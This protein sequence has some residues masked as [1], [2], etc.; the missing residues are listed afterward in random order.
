MGA[1]ILTC[2]SKS[3]NNIYKTAL[4]VTVLSSLERFLGF[5]YR[6]IL[7]RTIGSEGMG[8]YQIALSLFAVFVTAVSSGIPITVSRLITKHKAGGD[9]R[10]ERSAVSAGILLSLM[11]S[12]PVFLAVTLG[13]GLVSLLFADE[14]CLSIFLILS[15][16]LIFTSVYAVLRGALWGNRQFFTFSVIEL[17]EELVM[18]TLGTLLV[19]SAVSAADGA[20]R[21]AVAVT[22]SYVTSF[23]IAVIYFICKGGRLSSPKRQLKP[24]ILSSAPITAMRTSSS[25]INSLIAIILPARLMAAGMTSAEALSEFGMTSGMAVPVLFIPSTVIG[26]IAL[27]LVPELAE[28]FY[29]GRHGALK[30]DIENALKIS[31]AIACALIP[32]LFV[33]GE[34]VGVLLYS[35][36][37]SGKIISVF[38]PIL[39]PLSLNMI[40]TSM[41]NSMNLERKT[42]LYYLIS[43]AAMLAV[44]FIAPQ[45]IGA[46]ALP[47]GM[48]L[49]F[50]I[51]SALN[52]R[53]THK[54]CAQK[55]KYLSYMIKSCLC[56]I[57]AAAA[58]KAVY[59]LF[60][61]LVSALPA[62]IFTA[63]A[64]LGVISALF[65]ALGLISFK[66]VKKLLNKKTQQPLT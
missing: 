38:C 58:G 57:P 42:L 26:S 12:I 36:A 29:K 52:L 33:L 62:M 27:V 41:L 8:L 9:K 61:K 7:S 63:V 51:S 28:N 49:S 40:S 48:F 60:N 1:N 16:G 43:S 22:V 45:F 34:D 46:M 50:I 35:N 23:A 13:R 21:A 55:P 30:R 56:V 25:L 3:E 10:G 39:L 6:I 19:L 66:P 64:I 5:L 54:T 59:S 24:L 31:S 20:R 15:P 32:L 44:I 18:I 53:L 65:Y 17:I 4:Y 47:A 14:R 11:F 2:M 37:E